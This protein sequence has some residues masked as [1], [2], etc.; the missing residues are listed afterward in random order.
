MRWCFACVGAMV[1]LAIAAAEIAVAGAELVPQPTENGG[2]MVKL[3]AP[4]WLQCSF[5]AGQF[6]EVPEFCARLRADFQR[7]SGQ[8]LADEST[9]AKGARVLVVSVMLRD[10]HRASVTLA[11]GRQSARGFVPQTTQELRLG[12]ADAPLRAGSA[13]AL[14][15]P[16][17]GLLETLQ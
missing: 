13:A 5:A 1:A 4:V 10:S 17:V 6:P 14:V 12:G 16:L 3:D 2:I 8:A 15:Y 7:Q 11:A 9:P